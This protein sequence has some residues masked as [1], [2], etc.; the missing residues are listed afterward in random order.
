MH[1]FFRVQ[2][3]ARM[4]V[5]AFLAM[6]VQLS[7]AR[8][9]DNPCQHD[10]ECHFWQT[11]GSGGLQWL[12]PHSPFR[13][14][15][16]I[17]FVGSKNLGSYLI[18]T[19]KGNIL[20]NPSFDANVPMIKQSIEKLGFKYADTK[21]L[22]ISHAHSDHNAGAARIIRETGARYE[23]MAPDVATVESG[24]RQDF[25]Y[26]NKPGA[27]YAKAKGDG[28]G[29]AAGAGAGHARG[30]RFRVGLVAVGEHHLVSGLGEQ[31]AHRAADIARPDH[32]DLQGLAGPRH[33]MGDR[34]L[35]KGA[36]GDGRVL[37]KAGRDK[38]ERCGGAQDDKLAAIHAHDVSS[39]G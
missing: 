10:R 6:L 37:G 23:V 4:S 24:G 12:V 28:L 26:G 18:T 33:G 22:L 39:T 1:R 15:G 31:L 11:Q 29:A 9:A 27:L 20:I 38:A 14:A 5:A 8:A 35:D 2:F 32:A 17:Y 21:I 19:P 16:N 25:H 36:G 34:R 3:L 30:L 7:P 13:I